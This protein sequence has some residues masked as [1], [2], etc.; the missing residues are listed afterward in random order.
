MSV[1][2]RGALL[3]EL[4]LALV[5][6]GVGLAPAAW[7]FARAERLA[8]ASRARERATRAGLTLLAELPR[9]ACA[10]GAGARDDGVTS[11]RWTVSGDTLR[12]V[13]ATVEMGR[14]TVAETLR[15]RVAC[16]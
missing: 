6:L 2:S 4:L 7:L 10:A 14:G 12:T 5:L 13:V 1:P 9:T 8:G 15:T 16:P 11:V 3:P